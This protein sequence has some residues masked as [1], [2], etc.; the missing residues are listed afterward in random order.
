MMFCK[1]NKLKEQIE[2]LAL[3]I[4]KHKIAYQNEY[5]QKSKELQELKQSKAIQLE[6]LKRIEVC[7]PCCIDEILNFLL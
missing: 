6:Q 4:S 3:E 7:M 2:S 5:E 1:K